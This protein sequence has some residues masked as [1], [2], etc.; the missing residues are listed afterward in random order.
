L[1]SFIIGAVGMIAIIV[2]A[3]PNAIL[4]QSGLYYW[5]D[6]RKHVDNAWNEVSSLLKFRK[7]LSPGKYSKIKPRMV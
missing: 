1:W 7:L 5:E 2:F 4:D 3:C 6:G